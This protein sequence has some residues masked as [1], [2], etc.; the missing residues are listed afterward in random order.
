MEKKFYTEKQTFIDVI[1]PNITK[2]RS[3]KNQDHFKT[4]PSGT[5]S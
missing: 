5:E 2:L 4:D 1:I 3:L